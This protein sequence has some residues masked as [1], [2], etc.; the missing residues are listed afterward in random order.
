MI[1]SFRY[2]INENNDINKLN[3]ILLHYINGDMPDKYDNLQTNV[4]DLFKQLYEIFSDNSVNLTIM[5]DGKEFD[6]SGIVI[7]IDEPIHFEL[8]SDGKVISNK[9]HVEIKQNDDKQY[10]FSSLKVDKD[11]V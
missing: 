2:Y 11:E 3:K 7:K 5:K 10:F 1:K 4:K 6:G 8:S 9:L